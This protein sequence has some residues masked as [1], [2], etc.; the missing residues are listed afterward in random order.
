VRRAIQRARRRARW[1]TFLARLALSGA[2]TMATVVDLL[3]C[4]QLRRYK[5][6]LPVLYALLETLQVRQIIN[7]HCPTAAEV[8]HGT[9]AVV[10]ILN[11]LVA[12]RPLYWV[13]DWVARTVLVY[14]LGVLAEK[15]ND[16]RLGRTL[17]AIG[18][19][20]REIWQDVVHRALVQ[21]NVDLH[22]IFYDLTA[23]VVHGAYSD[24]QLADFGFAHLSAACLCV[25]A[26]RQ[27]R[28]ATRRW[29]SASSKTV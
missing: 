13:A 21:A 18:Q 25:Y 11:R 28:Q 6:A 9:V 7:R 26:R 16:D 8:D 14:T 24:S 19:H 4:S 2:L 23:F 12:P 20:S 22:V 1:L 17:E 15:F 5:G 29:T 10:L 3:T 27:A